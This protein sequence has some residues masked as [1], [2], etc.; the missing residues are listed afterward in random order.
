MVTTTTANSA[1]GTPQAQD[2]YVTTSEDIGIVINVL[3][4][5]LGGAA[6]SLYSVS[7]TNPLNVVTTATSTLGALVYITSDGQVYYDP[8]QSSAVQALS[9]G[10]RT[11]D[12]FVYEERLGN[13]TVSQATVHVTVT[14]ANDA[15]VVSGK[16]VAS[17]TEDGA[18]VTL[19]ALA[20]A[21][22]VDAGTLLSVVN[23]P[24]AL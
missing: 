6:K 10:Q 7:Q 24:S 18:N 9:V 20:N 23:M 17:A 1:N 11:V 12:T 19:N 16:V 5:D 22:D 8:T 4:N 2:D 14:G 3:A 21:S 13:G 15:P